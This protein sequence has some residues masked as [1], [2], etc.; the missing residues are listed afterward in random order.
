MRSVL[1]AACLLAGLCGPA[2]AQVNIGINL[3]VYPELVPVPGYPVYYAPQLD[4]NYFFYDG[5]YW[6]YA[7]DGWYSSSW[8]D[9]PWDLVTPEFVP[10]FVLRVPVRYYRQPPV[11][12]RGWV[13]EAAPRW[14]EHWG[15]D[16]EQ[17]RAG[18][19]HWDRASAPAPAPLP[20]YQRNYSGNRYPHAAQQQALRSQNYPYQPHESAGRP[21]QQQG[22]LPHRQPMAPAAQAS[23]E[24]PAR[25]G[26]QGVA[27]GKPRPE[28]AAAPREPKHEPQ[29]EPQRES[30][31]EPQREAERGR[32]H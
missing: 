31:R 22:Q 32:D 23:H 13:G 9:G 19:N 7:Q 24:A 6:V 8:Y 16:W 18:W 12:F 3:S 27:P 4:S 30:K 17:R 15:R 29:R 28:Q 10:V 21:Q 1:V 14:G 11:F 26:N 5:L 2:A 20:V 25:P